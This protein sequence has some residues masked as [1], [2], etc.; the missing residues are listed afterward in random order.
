[1]LNIPIKFCHKCSFKLGL[2]KATKPDSL[3]FIFR[4]QSKHQV[5][6]A[7][8]FWKST[9]NFSWKPVLIFPVLR[10]HIGNLSKMIWG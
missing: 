6:P 2:L 10:N 1:M 9:D 3:Q 4:I 7:C 5:P 8:P